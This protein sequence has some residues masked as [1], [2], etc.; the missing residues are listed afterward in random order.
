MTSMNLRVNIS[1]MLKKFSEDF[2]F[3]RVVNIVDSIFYY[4]YFLKLFNI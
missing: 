2:T 3:Y 1:K 4:N